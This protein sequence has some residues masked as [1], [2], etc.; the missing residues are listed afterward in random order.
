[1]KPTDGT[2]S[3]L[4]KPLTVADTHHNV[5]Q[6]PNLLLLGN[7]IWQTFW[8][9]FD[10]AVRLNVGLND[11]QKFNYL[12]GK[13]HGDATCTC[14]CVI[15]GSPLTKKNYTQ[16]VELLKDRFGQPYNIINAHLEALLNLT[17]PSNNLASLQAFMIPFSHYQHLVNHMVCH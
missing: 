8:N 17:K 1:M 2:V 16:S 5:S 14:T 4:R 11:V 12:H 9:S 3:T 10:A 6:L 7:F 13:L 15:A